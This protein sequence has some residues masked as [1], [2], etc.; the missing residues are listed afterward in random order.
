MTTDAD[1]HHCGVPYLLIEVDL[2][3][4]TQVLGRILEV[5]EEGLGPPTELVGRSIVRVQ[6]DGSKPRTC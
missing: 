2:A 3:G 6:L 4:C 5:A 1:P